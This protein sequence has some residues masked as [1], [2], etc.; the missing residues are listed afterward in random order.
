[1][2]KDKIFIHSNEDGFSA[3]NVSAICSVGESTKTSIRGYIGEKGIGFKSVF[4]VARRVHVRSEPYSFAFEYDY[5]LPDSGLGMVT[6]LPEEYSQ[7]SDGIRT[8]MVL[9]LRADCN[10]DNLF[11][12]FKNLPATFLLFLEK[13]KKLSFRIEQPG[14]GTVEN[15]Y[16]RSTEN[17]RATITKAVGGVEENF[18]FWIK[19]KTVES[20]PED[21]KRTI[22]KDGKIVMRITKADVI[23]ALP[24]DKED[25]P[26]VDPQPV[27]AFLPM[28]KV[29]FKV[30][31]CIC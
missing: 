27:F 14:G 8:S 24:L 15:V 1:M 3:A 10:R 19:E 21:D 30:C 20:M 11:H 6:P 17:N 28:R 4:K 22:K 12:E 18:Y 13:L 7:L 9:S 16:T 31:L 5:D 29:G 23:L 26:I 2:S 25:V